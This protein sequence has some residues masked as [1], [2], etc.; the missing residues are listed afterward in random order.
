MND[1]LFDIYFNEKSS[2]I[3]YPALINS[4]TKIINM[5]ILFKNV[6]GNMFDLIK[7]N[8]NVQSRQFIN[9]KNK[10]DSLENKKSKFE[11]KEFKNTEEYLITEL[12]SKSKT[13]DRKKT[14]LE[15]STIF[16]NNFYDNG[17]KCYFYN[18]ELKQIFSYEIIFLSIETL[19]EFNLHIKYSI[20]VM[21]F[22]GIMFYLHLKADFQKVKNFSISD[23][24]GSSFSARIRHKK[25][26][27]DMKKSIGI[28]DNEFNINKNSHSYLAR[29][30]NSD[31]LRKSIHNYF[32]QIY[33]SNE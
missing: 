8:L 23:F 9:V 7:T 11:L 4:G 20:L 21:N 33:E 18:E 27:I 15:L 1:F 3:Y 12:M 14:F 28:E 29:Y 16:F 6:F 32:L 25:K 19:C 24:M 10:L 30:V 17:D 5:M 31:F 26:F 2:P 13:D 22:V